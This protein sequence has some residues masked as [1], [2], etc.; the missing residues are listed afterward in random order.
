MRFLFSDG[1]IRRL[2]MDVIHLHPG[3]RITFRGTA[4]GDGPQRLLPTLAFVTR[5][6]GHRVALVRT[7][8]A[9]RDRSQLRRTELWAERLLD[10]TTATFIV[11]DPDAKAPSADRTVMIP[12]AHYRERYLGYPR[13]TQVRGRILCCASV[14]LPNDAVRVMEASR[15][16]APQGVG[17]RVVGPAS[18]ALALELEMRSEDRLSVQLGAASDGSLV[19]EITA[20]ELVVLPRLDTLDDL[21]I[22]LMSL[23]LNRPVLLPPGPRAQRIYEEV[24]GSWVIVASTPIDADEIHAALEQVRA[25][26]TSTQPNLEG[27]GLSETSRAYADAFRAAISSVRGWAALNGRSRV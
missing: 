15:H 17:I 12:H 26:D 7:V 6:R 16:L 20:A 24:G 19:E 13:A 9:S 5:L 8:H 18:P 14:E 23:S 10:W 3:R 4:P 11:L 1:D 27:R 2:D 21:H 25:P 22:A